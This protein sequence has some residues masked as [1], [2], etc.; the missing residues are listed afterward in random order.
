M[1]GLDEQDEQ[2]FRCPKCNHLIDF[3]VLC[4]EYNAKLGEEADE[5]VWL[6]SDSHIEKT[7]TYHSN[8]RKR[9]QICGTPYTKMKHVYSVSCC[10]DQNIRHHFYAGH[11]VFHDVVERTTQAILVGNVNISHESRSDVLE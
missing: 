9:V 5:W 6:H 1:S 11:K 7:P 2:V 10:T 8:L 4:D 3:W